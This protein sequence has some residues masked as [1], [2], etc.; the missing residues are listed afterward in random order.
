MLYGRTVT[1]LALDIEGRSQ[2]MP[3]LHWQGAL[4]LDAK[5][6][7]SMPRTQRFTA[8]LAELAAAGWLQGTED[9]ALRMVA[10]SLVEAQRAKVAVGGDLAQRLL[11]AVGG[12]TQALRDVLGEAACKAV[13]SEIAPHQLAQLVLA[14]L[15]PSVLPRLGDTLRDEGLDPPKRWGSDEA[16]AFVAAIGF[17]DVYATA[18]DAKRDAEER[19]DGPIELKK[20]HDFQIE[21]V[22]GIKRLIDSGTGRR[23]AVV[24]LPTGGGKTRV[25]V[26][27][28]VELI[29][30]PD[31]PRRSVLWVAQTDELCEQAVQCFRQVWLNLG[32]EDTPLRIVRLWGGHRN[33]SPSPDGDPTVLVAS[34]QTLSSRIGTEGMA[35]L[36][37]PGLVVVDEC[38]HAITKSYSGLLRWLDA[39]PG[40]AAKVE[41]PIIG[42]SATPFRGQNSDDENERLARRFDKRWLPPQQEDLYRTLQ[43]QGILA[44][45]DHEALKSTASLLDDEIEKLARLDGDSENIL[46]E[47]LLD[48]IN[49]RLAGNLVRNRMLIDRI[50]SSHEAQILFFANSV[51]HASEMAARFNLE[52]IASAAVSGD[53][54]KSARRYFLDRFHRGELRVLCNHSVLTTGFDA[55][56]TDMVLI[57]RQVLS[58]V[59]YMQMVGRG[60]RGTKNGGTERCRIV[61]VIDNLGRFANKHPYHLCARYFTKTA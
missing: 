29:L 12:Q 47:N 54:P 22:E 34:I 15:G 40:P 50:K 52:G 59:R 4:L 17:P 20:L 30:K 1:D 33:P 21:V 35:W 42:L 10:D 43:A 46:L 7:A 48:E 9:A 27:A 23:R 36:S 16:R 26:Q 41:P 39:V 55:P 58:P 6:L 24:S 13:S 28:A 51:G 14:M 19:I 25:T 44:A 38:H 49:R 61:T 18:T 2:A 57:A 5:Q 8:I 11:F 31:G 37:T 3:C 45:V 53:T 60:L 32:A 56:K